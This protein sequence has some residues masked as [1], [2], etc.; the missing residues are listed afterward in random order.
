MSARSIAVNVNGERRRLAPD[1]TLAQLLSEL[2]PNGRRFAVERNG[3]I[4]PRS[5]HG[6][7]ALADGDRLEIVVAVGG[8]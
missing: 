3:T 1:T 4:V 6:S 7:T 5:Q 2:A 8:G